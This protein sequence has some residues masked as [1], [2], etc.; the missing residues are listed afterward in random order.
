MISTEVAHNLGQSESNA[1]LFNAAVRISHCL[2]LHKIVDSLHKPIEVR[3][4]YY[5]KVERELGKRLWCILRIQDH[6]AIY[7]T[8]SYGWFIPVL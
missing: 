2:G 6:F 5:E 3:E 1:I 4:Q 7:F 8:D